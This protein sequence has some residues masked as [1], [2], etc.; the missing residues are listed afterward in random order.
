MMNTTTIDPAEITAT[1]RKLVLAGYKIIPVEGKIPEIK[2]WPK[3]NAGLDDL[4]RWGVLYP[5]Y[6]NTGTLAAHTPAVDIDIMIED[7]AN[8]A[9]DLL[10]QRFGRRGTFLVRCGMYPKR[11][12]PFRTDVPFKKIAVA[13]VAKDGGK[14][15]KIEILCDGQQFVVHG[16]HP[17]TREPYTW[18][19]G[20]LWN[21]A[22][23]KLPTISEQ[24]ARDFVNDA[25]TM[26]VEHFGFEI[27]VAIN[28]K[29]TDHAGQ[30]NELYPHA[31]IDTLR[32]ALD[33]IPN[34]YDWDGWNRVGMALWRAT[35]GS[36]FDLFDKWSQK[37]SNYIATTTSATW[38]GYF[39][40]PPTRL[41]AGTIIHLA[42]EHSPNWRYG[43]FSG[44]EGTYT[45]L[46]SIDPEGEEGQQKQEQKQEQKQKQKQKQKQEQPS[47]P[48]PLYPPLPPAEPYPVDALGTNLAS[49]AY[50]VSRKIQVPEAIAAQ[51]VLSVACLAAQALADV[52][53]PFGQVRPL[54]CFFV[55]VAQTGDRKTSADSEV[56]SAI[57]RREADLREAFKEDLAEHK[58]CMAAYLAVKKGVENAKGQTVEE[59][60]REILA[61]GP[62]PQPPLS[63]F[64]TAPD[65]TIEGLLK[66]WKH[67]PASLGLFSAEGGQFVG[68]H[69][70]TDESKLRTAAALSELWDGV[71]PKRIRAG[72]G[73]SILPGRR[74][75]LHMLVQP[76][77]SAV[78]LSDRALKDQGLLSRVL[79]AAPESIAGT[80]FYNQPQASDDA[81]IRD[82]ERVIFNMLS[83]R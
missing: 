57:R 5:S 58:A 59:K 68:G 65:P 63:P 78:F 32:R 35:N 8:A 39:R 60:T 20:E 54:S 22:H 43:F 81:A 10:R 67:A 77:A 19:G 33:V 2:G 52:R 56:S 23:E 30:S 48:L 3:I 41:G 72:D 70:M 74:L 82:F 6:I 16:I 76:E 75:A 15:P 79:S 50:A 27:K 46:P 51:S 83:G 4:P 38:N 9:E 71:P 42:N 64:L 18:K 24:E 40:S 69:G 14:D 7:A 73:V 11:A 13:F 45:E 36:G 28:P 21:T 55:T 12:V 37:S 80:R 26:L 1:R 66:A 49:A 61:L 25:T 34:N 29:S 47:E 53:L 31:D 62:E 17:E 44:A